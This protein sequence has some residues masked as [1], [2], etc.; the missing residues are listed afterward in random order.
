MRLGLSAFQFFYI[1]FLIPKYVSSW[2]LPHT[3]RFRRRWQEVT[4]PIATP[5]NVIHEHFM[6]MALE[7]SIVAGKCGE[8]PIGALV[9]R[10]VTD[11]D[12][13]GGNDPHQP[14]VHRLQVL[15]SSHNQVE[16]KY[17]ASAH[18][19]LLAMRQAARRIRN[20]RL[21]SCTLYSTLEPCVVCLA[22]CQAF[23][24]SRVVYGASDFRLGAVHSHIALLD[25]AQHPFHNVTSVIGGVHNTTSAELLRSFFRSRRAKKKLKQSDSLPAPG[26]KALRFLRQI[27]PY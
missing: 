19:E 23:R 1:V 10:N 13:N 18:A 24:V 22:S 20:W 3:L 26:R 7:Q 25:M 17:D 21:Q 6:T 14:S 16:Q 8:V 4:F 27:S 2:G 5:I 15:G 12:A 11:N 9:V